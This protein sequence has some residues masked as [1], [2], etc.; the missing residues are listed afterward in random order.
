MFGN[1]DTFSP[2]WNKRLEN[3]GF[4]SKDISNNLLIDNRVLWATQAVPQATLHVLNFFKE[5]GYGEFQFNLLAELPNAAE[6]H[7]L[8]PIQN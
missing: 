6:L 4:N 5:N 8:S 1:W 2:Q 7:Y 3:L